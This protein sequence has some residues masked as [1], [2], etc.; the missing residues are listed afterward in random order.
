MLALVRNYSRFRRSKALLPTSTSHTRKRDCEIRLGLQCQIHTTACNEFHHW[1]ALEISR[2][3]R[4][5]LK[6]TLT[7]F[8]D[9]GSVLG[10]LGM[11]V[12]FLSLIWTC[13]ILTASI[14]H[15]AFPSTNHTT[16]T[17]GLVKRDGN[18]FEV[19]PDS[20]IKIIVSLIVTQ[21]NNL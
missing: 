20:H 4:A 1:L 15:R 14:F 12:V 16:T 11:V 17:P 8:Y 19:A 13:G 10:I 2:A 18:Y 21:L 5:K 9:S 3:R 6:A 7:N